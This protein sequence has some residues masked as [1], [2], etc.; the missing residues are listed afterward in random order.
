[1]NNDNEILFRKRRRYFYHDFC[2]PFNA[3]GNIARDP[4][5]FAGLSKD[6]EVTIFHKRRGREVR[7]FYSDPERWQRASECGR[8]NW[9]KWPACTTTKKIEEQC[10]SFQLFC[11]RASLS[12]TS[13]SSFEPWWQWISQSVRL[14]LITL[15]LSAR[16]GLTNEKKKKKEFC[17]ASVENYRSRGCCQRNYRT[18]WQLHWLTC[19]KKDIHLGTNVCWHTYVA[20]VS[21]HRYNMLYNLSQIST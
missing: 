21:R 11:C 9:C 6:G 14:S 7:P 2:L 3:V 15:W 13:K 20:C 10:H 17:F 18:K 8:C 4:K 1:M 16:N 5:L 12:R 19:R